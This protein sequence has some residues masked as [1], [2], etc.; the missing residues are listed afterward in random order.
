MRKGPRRAAS[1]PKNGYVAPSDALAAA[2]DSDSFAEPRPADDAG[3]LLTLRLTK[4]GALATDRLTPRMRTRIRHAFATA[5]AADVMGLGPKTPEDAATPAPFDGHV[6]G[7]IYDAL[8]SIAVAFAQR[9]G[10]TEDEALVLK[11]TGSEKEVLVPPTVNLMNKYLGTAAAQDETILA[12]SLG[13]ML[14]SKVS[15][16]R[17][18]EDDA[19]QPGSP[20]HFPQGASVL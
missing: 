19:A 4:S 13:M 17:H 9:A 11:F 5:D 7:V 6:C 1:V 18:V 3:S 8:G 2:S 16:L 12:L 14:M 15:Q 10:Y 20:L